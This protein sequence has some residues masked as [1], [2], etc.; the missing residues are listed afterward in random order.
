MENT[1]GRGRLAAVPPEVDHWNWG[2]FL[3]NWIWGIAHNT[4]IALLMF[5]PGV[6]FVMPFVLGARGS[7]WAWRNRRWESIEHFR[8]AQR[9]WARW[10]FGLLLAAVAAAGTA[11]WW[12]AT[13]ITHS[14]PYRLALHAV[15]TSREAAAELGAPI[16]PGVPKGGFEF[17]DGTGRADLEIPVAGPRGRGTVLLKARMQGG[18]WRL[19][20]LELLTEAGRR[21][22]LAPATGGRTA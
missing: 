4:W 3:L 14:E 10:G 9:A 22:D 21:I 8:R 11:L 16:E 2:A 12:V 17:A 7:V 20:R 19:E 5:V 18:E 6:N 15:A 1:S 13:A